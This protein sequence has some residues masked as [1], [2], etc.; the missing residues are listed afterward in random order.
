M[1]ENNLSLSTAFINPI[2]TPVNEEI[3]SRG[4]PGTGLGLPCH[5]DRMMMQGF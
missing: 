1:E 5:N 3:T 4:I 2:I